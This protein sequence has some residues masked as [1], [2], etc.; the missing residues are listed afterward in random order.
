MVFL[1]V[2][3]DILVLTLPPQPPLASPSPRLRQ[4]SSTTDGKSQRTIS[5]CSS[6]VSPSHAR[7]GSACSDIPLCDI[8]ELDIEECDQLHQLT[9]YQHLA[10][11]MT[12]EEVEWLL[13]DEIASALLQSHPVKVK[14]M[15]MVT[16]HVKSSLKSLSC[17]HEIIP[18]NF[19]ASPQQC[20]D[21]FKEELKKMKLP[22]YQLKEV[23][24]YFYILPTKMQVKNLILL[25]LRSVLNSKLHYLAK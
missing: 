5:L 15:E 6:H 14:T 17:C 9:N 2:T 24:S 7:T 10:V 3:L 20:V 4:T 1:Q 25:P 13:R 23:E 12:K 22:G 16:A 18:L 19:V 8:D 11:T 21:M